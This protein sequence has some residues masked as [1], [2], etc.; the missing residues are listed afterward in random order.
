MKSSTFGQGMKRSGDGPF[1][2]SLEVLENQ[3]WVGKGVR[4]RGDLHFSGILRF[5]GEWLGW[6]QGATQDSHLFVMLGATVSGQVQA[7]EVTVEGEM[8]DVDI[9]T[10]RFRALSGSRVVG[11]VRAKTLV[12]EPGAIVEGAIVGA[13]PLSL[14]GSEDRV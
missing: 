12:I 3:H 7:N 9:T 10:H 8:L 13:Q 5:R 11:T 6:I 1:W 4:G 2:D 14:S